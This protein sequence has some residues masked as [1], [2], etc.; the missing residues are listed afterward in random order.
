MT[1]FRQA[2]A[3]TAA[4]FL[5][6]EQFFFPALQNRIPQFDLCHFYHTASTLDSSTFTLMF[7]NPT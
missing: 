5:R 7:T 3:L 2:T 4:E 1:T 6:P